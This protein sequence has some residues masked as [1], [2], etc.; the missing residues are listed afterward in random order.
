MKQQLW[1]GQKPFMTLLEEAWNQQRHND[2]LDILFLRLCYK[3]KLEG[4]IVNYAVIQ[5]LPSEPAIIRY[6]DNSTT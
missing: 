3:S 4:I 6:A 5:L 2:S 1:E